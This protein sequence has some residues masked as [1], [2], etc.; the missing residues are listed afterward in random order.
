MKADFNA[1]NKIV[2]GNR[3]LETVRENN[4]MPEEIF[5]EKNRMTD[6]GTVAKTLFCDITRQA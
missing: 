5:S 6:D 2:Y 3:I 4:M 1:T